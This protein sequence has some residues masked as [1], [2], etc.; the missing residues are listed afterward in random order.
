MPFL[1][2]LAWRDLRASG[3][4]LWIFVACLVLGVSLVA[5]SG[6]LYRQVADALRSD[7]RLI[8][9][10]DVEVQANQ[11]LPSE[12][13]A[14]MQANGTVSRVVELRTMLRTG[15]G[16]AQLIELLSADD[17]YPLY[18]EVL[19][20]PGGALVDTLALR[21]GTWGAAIDASL[22]TRLD[23]KPGDRVAIGDLELVVRA[24]TVRQPDRSL[25]ADWGAAPVLVAEGAL[26]ATG[27]VQPLSRVEYRYRIRTEQSAPI[28]RDS[29]LT[30]Y[31]ALDVE[32]RSFD[33]RSDRMTE[34]LGQIGSGLLLIGFSALFIGGLGVFNS[35]QAY[36][37]GKLISLATLRA[38][39]LRDGQLAAFI[40]LQILLLAVL[41]SA[42]GVAI[43]MG[44][45]LSGAQLAADK[46]PVTLLL[47]SLWKPALIALLF[48][49][50]TAL[51]FSLPAL[52]RALS[53]SPAAL[54]RGVEGQALHAPRYARWWTA[55]VSGITM[56]LLVFTLPDPR[57]GLAFVFTTA[58]LLGVLDLVTRG[59]RRAAT[60]MQHSASL[61]LALRLALAGL[62]QQ[63]SPLRTALLSLGSALTLLVACTLVVAT[64]LR[65]VN[66][67]VPEKAPA[68]VFYD[69]QTD[70]ISLLKETLQASPG[71]QGLKTA[72]L[73]LGRLVA[74][75]GETLRDS[76]DNERA[77]ESR[78]EHKLSD[79]SGNFDDVVV[80]RGV[81]WPESHRGDPFVAM[82][83]READGLGLQIGDKLRFEVMG[84]PVEA[85]LQA[86]Y[87]Q[88]RMQSRLWLEAIFSDG[89]LD[90]FITRH[91]GAAWMPPE[92]ALD[93]Q[94]R[95]AAVAPNIATARTESMLRETRALM[96]RAS[97]G[98]A[99]IAGV[100]LAA[101]LLVLASVVA[102]SRTRQLYDATVM[103]ALGARHSLLRRVL[104]F[105]YLILAA[106]TASFS[107]AAGSALATA[108]LLWRLDMSPVGLYWSGMLTAVVTSGL[109]LGMGARYLLAR[110]RL[111]PAVLLR[112]GG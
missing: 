71:L 86:I 58:A 34:V 105:E 63:H 36:L 32:A 37:Q 50:L 75:N 76:D 6:G 12:A 100:C 39:G 107:I 88:R 110:M 40:L 33:E 44:L 94:D 60:R 7:A 99:V 93:A 70:Q 35:V 49:V 98:L 55:A 73:V 10:G 108:L 17:A 5:A 97:G 109:S 89:V 51:A 84:K 87:S 112:S 41:A 19:L 53:V 24:V 78:D 67:T 47:Q 96:G 52:G 54:F 72:P 90:T 106:V 27:L 43:G 95:L 8:F 14:W 9:G 59:L 104:V 13:L 28:L 57:F 111:N 61:P 29:F 65:T 11:P 4:Q 42:V 1:L 66:K 82:E 62:Q 30:A 64:L 81:W 79:R 2:S 21:D 38:L 31:P 20:E 92:N 46:L 22:A 103:H 16:R 80:D 83:D 48:G 45:A 18:G 25:R 69:V 15:S 74:V 77:R 102:A 26:M 101:S 85:T 3:S 68:L 23:L 56:V 91:V